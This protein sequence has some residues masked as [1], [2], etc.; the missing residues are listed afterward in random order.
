M[1]KTITT[2]K[3]IG[4]LFM[5][6]LI[7]PSV[8]CAE[9]VERDKPPRDIT[10]NLGLTAGT[11]YGLFRDMGAS[12]T[13]FHGAM[14]NPQLTVERWMFAPIR[15]NRMWVTIDGGVGVYA[16]AQS[17]LLQLQ[18]DAVAGLGVMEM[19]Y[20]QQL[21]QRSMYFKDVK[22]KHKLDSLNIIEYKGGY[23]T[24][25]PFWGVSLDEY[26]FLSA[27]PNLENSSTAL[28]CMSMPVLRGGLGCRYHKRCKDDSFFVFL[29]WSSR[30][31]VCIAPMGYCLRPGFAYLDNYNAS[32][33]DI[34]LNNFG[35]NYRMDPVFLPWCN[36][37]LSVT[38]HFRNQNALGLC[39]GWHF[40]TSRD[41]G[42]YRLEESVHMVKMQ[43]TVQLIN[44][45]R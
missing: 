9:T 26:L 24:V 7:V 35:R 22:K 15:K 10:W 29:R 27:I 40:L 38:Y 3:T 25:N 19:G 44:R 6:L 39:Y 1:M 12:P 28:S 21:F 30:A 11:G 43:L 16:K 23:L 4:T 32:N 37:E 13:T 5:L 17:N 18:T 2:Y 42:S 8:L 31:V 20:E 36:T 14:F 41:S 33:G 34:I 45:Q